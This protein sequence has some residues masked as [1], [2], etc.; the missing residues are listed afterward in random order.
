MKT[1]E[2]LTL[3]QVIL[4]SD[5]PTGDIILD[6]ALKHI[7]DTPQPETVTNWIEYLSGETWNPLKLRYQVFRRYYCLLSHIAKK[8]SATQYVHFKYSKTVSIQ[9]ILSI[10]VKNIPDLP[11]HIHTDI[12]ASKSSNSLLRSR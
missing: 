9:R 4:K 6:E 10:M 1:C 8:Y 5:Q 7:K 2:N 12:S 11:L 3:F